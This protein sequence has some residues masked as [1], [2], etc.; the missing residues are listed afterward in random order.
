MPNLKV[1][2]YAKVKPAEREKAERLANSAAGA[3]LESDVAIEAKRTKT[4]VPGESEQGQSVAAVVNFTD[5][6][7]QQVRE[8]LANA[9]SAKEVEEI[10][11]A[12]RRGVLPVALMQRKRKRE[13][14]TNKVSDDE[15]PAKKSKDS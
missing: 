5:E 1:L 9:S 12:I 7:R 6:E 11:A 3:A 13:E 4:F 14:G 2:D 8:L 15:V 10:E